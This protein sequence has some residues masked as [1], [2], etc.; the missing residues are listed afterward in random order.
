MTKI[1]RR[2]A[3]HKMEL[4]EKDGMEY[5]VFP[6]LEDT[7][8]VDHLFSTRIGGVSQKEFAQSNFSYTRGDDPALV[9]ENY[10]RISEILG[11]GHSAEDFVLT[12]QTHTTNI[13]R[14]YEEDRGKG[15]VRERGYT[16]IDGLITNVPGIILATFHADCTPLYFV[17]PVHKAIGLAHSG[18]RGTAGQMGRKMLLEMEKAYGTKPEDCIC[19]IGPS[20][21]GGCYEV[22]EDVALVFQQEYALEELPLFSMESYESMS[23]TQRPLLWKKENDKYMLDLW[24]VNRRILLE[25]GVPSTQICTTDI[26]SCCNPELLFSHR[27]QHEKRGNLAAFLSLRG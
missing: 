17:D 16:D 14:V 4:R 1:K 20:I 27:V 25:S 21:C 3:D 7:G 9:T 10:C 18:W 19:A 23:E 13:K 26:C 12:F 22:S 2:N 11:H 5:L 8:I 15:T 6:M 24:A